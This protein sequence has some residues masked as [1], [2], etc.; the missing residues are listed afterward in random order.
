MA[1]RLLFNG[2]ETATKALI[3][4]GAP[5]TIF[6][7]GTGDLLAVEFPASTAD[8]PTHINLLGE[9]WNAVTETVTLALHPAGEPTWEAEVDFVMEEGL[10]FAI[11][12]YEGFLNQWAVGVNGYHGY[13]TI[14]HVEQFDARQPPEVRRQLEG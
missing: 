6:P 14:E 10:P 1:V 12:G 13:V 2:C 4:T 7:R 9:R 3:D 11:L 5:R 8:A